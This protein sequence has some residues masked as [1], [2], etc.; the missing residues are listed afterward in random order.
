MKNLSKFFFM[1][2]MIQ[3]F[4]TMAQKN[5]TLLDTVNYT[6][7]LAGVW[8][9]AHNGKEYAI[10]G[11]NVGISI[12]DVTTPTAPVV[13]PF[14]P[15]PG[16]TNLW[17]EVK[18]WG[19]YAYAVTEGVSANNALNGLQVINLSYLPDSA[20]NHFWT[21]DSI[22]A[23][24]LKNA[25]TVAADN[26]YVYING[27]H[28]DTLVGGTHLNQGVIIA[29]LQ[30]PWNPHYAGAET[31]NYCH[32]CYVRGDTMFTSDIY[33]GIFSV[34]N[35][36]NR[37]NPVLLATQQTP[38][39]FNHTCWLSDNGKYLFT[40]DEKSG[41]PIGSYDISNLSNIQLL[42]VYYTINMQPHEP[43]NVRVLNDFI[44]NSSYG[45]QVTIVDAAHPD[46]LIEVGN[47]PTGNSLCWDADPFLP[48]GIILATDMN[49]YKLYI[50]GPTY[51]RACYLEGLVTDSIT[52][53]P[54]IFAHVDILSTYVHDSTDISGNYK[55]GIADSGS[56]QVQYSKTGYI[57]RTI[58]QNLSHGVLTPLNVKL[59]PSNVGLTDAEPQP[60][61]KIKNN[62][63]SNIVIEIS[64][65]ALKTSGS[66]N[67][68][69]SD[70][71]G[72]V[73][74][75]KSNVTESHIYLNKNSLSAGAYYFSLENGD[76][77]ISR[78]KIIFVS[79]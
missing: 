41:A 19:N 55:T 51:I 78:G 56:Y 33:A 53:M 10:V 70:E 48:S 54:I 65:E 8:H 37:A 24:Q 50:F 3:S 5:I 46:N 11:S 18:V 25:H 64:E 49:S 27:H 15:L 47:Y 71:L 77:L 72:R 62:P 16:V 1:V 67:L 69:L 9:Y 39:Q 12:V 63:S 28:V 68:I 2:L 31:R 26:G 4:E 60:W 58:T 57:T 23:G 79:N 36:A 74:F 61:V 13:L 32:D 22:L 42:D 73:V 66:V 75:R 7:T 34:F 20:P 76:K 43:H 21:G 29:S 17:H 38:A 59:V 6:G 35:I 14:C 44:I 45:S 52:H 30:D 40:T